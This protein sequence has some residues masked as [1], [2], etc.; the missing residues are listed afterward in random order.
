M[1][2]LGGQGAPGVRGD[3]GAPGFAGSPGGPGVMGPPGV[4]GKYVLY[5]IVKKVSHFGVF[6]EAY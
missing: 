1:G 6:M 2:F 4:Q 3:I 5:R